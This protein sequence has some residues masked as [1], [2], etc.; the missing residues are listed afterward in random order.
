MLY[1]YRCIL[2]MIHCILYLYTSQFFLTSC[3]FIQERTSFEI[4]GVLI[5]FF[6]KIN[7]NNDHNNR[8]S[9]YFLANAIAVYIFHTN[10]LAYKTL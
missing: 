6:I 4:I 9:I 5:T 2:I 8:I 3:T 1:F 10:I 7:D